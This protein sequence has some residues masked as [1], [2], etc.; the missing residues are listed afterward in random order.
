[1]KKPAVVECLLDSC[2]RSR[3]SDLGALVG[4]LYKNVFQRHKGPPD[5]CSRIFWDCNPAL[6]LP[7]MSKYPIRDCYTANNREIPVQPTK[8]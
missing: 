2:P 6:P 3:A 7:S 4:M 8:L 5:T 1:M